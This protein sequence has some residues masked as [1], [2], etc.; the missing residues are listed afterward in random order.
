MEGVPGDPKVAYVLTC[1]RVFRNYVIKC[2]YALRTHVFT[3]RHT[4]SPLPLTA[5]V[6]TWS[7]ANMLYL[8]SN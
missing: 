8:L 5:C 3:Y 7:P 6:T 2:D 1:Q 4:L